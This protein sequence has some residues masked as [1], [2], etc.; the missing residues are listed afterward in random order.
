M[1]RPPP[2]VL[3]FESG[4]RPVLNLRGRRWALV[5]Y[6]RAPWLVYATAAGP[7]GVRLR[8][9]RRAPVV[10]EVGIFTVLVIAD[11]AHLV[12]LL[13]E[14]INSSDD[15]LRATWAAAGFPRDVR[16]VAAS[17]PIHPGDNTD[18]A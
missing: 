9:H 18:E 13:T 10:F 1:V 7:R 8:S 2:P 17:A 15:T 14:E 3:D 11:D 12:T 16:P 4:A 5:R 6:R